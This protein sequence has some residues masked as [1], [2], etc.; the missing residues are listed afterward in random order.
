MKRMHS[1]KEIKEIAESGG[2]SVTINV[3]AP[4]TK[5]VASDVIT[6][7][8]DQ[9]NIASKEELQEVAEN[10]QE[11]SE[12]IL[13]IEKKVF[14]DGYEEIWRNTNLH[15]D[16]PNSENIWTSIS[17]V[18][19]TGDN[20]IEISNFSQYKQILIEYFYSSDPYRQNENLVNQKIINVSDIVLNNNLYTKY[21][22][23]GQNMKFDCGLKIEKLIEEDSSTS[24]SELCFRGCELIYDTENDRGTLAFEGNAKV[25]KCSPNE[26]TKITFNMSNSKVL[27][28][29][30]I[31]IKKLD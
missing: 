5:T 27:V 19:P 13:A 28:S 8:L 15:E 10:V 3:V 25:I 21:Y 26:T 6:V 1:E 16:F 2:S 17:V 18:F 12:D 31:G 4:I 29:R 24:D 20:Q 11:I 22:Y 23:D 9:T 7:G 30:I 14:N